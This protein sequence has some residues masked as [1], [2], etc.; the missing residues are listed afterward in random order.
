M[1]VLIVKLADVTIDKQDGGLVDQRFGIVAVSF[2]RKLRVSLC[3]LVVTLKE[4][5]ESQ[6]GGGVFA[7]GRRPYVIQPAP[8]N[9][10]RLESMAGPI[11][12][13]QRPRAGLRS[14]SRTTRAARTRAECSSA[15]RS[16]YLSQFPATS[17]FRGSRG[18][19]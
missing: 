8:R 17:T 5:N 9:E 10:Q 6:V 1:N 2:D 16:K 11:A 7:H 15:A 19:T 4:L 12:P 13:Y 18:V 14:A 3:I